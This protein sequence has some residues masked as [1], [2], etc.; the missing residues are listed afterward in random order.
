[1]FL[2]AI[3]RSCRSF[4]RVRTAL[5]SAARQIGRLFIARSPAEIRLIDIALLRKYRNAGV[6]TQ[7]N[8][9]LL[10]EAALAFKPV[11]IHVESFN[12]ALRLDQRLGFAKLPTAARAGL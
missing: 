3:S 5:Y 11:R 9:A 10:H 12:P 2:Y 6:G 8:Y 1:M 4:S 7:L